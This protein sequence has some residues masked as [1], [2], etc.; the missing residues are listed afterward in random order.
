MVP[1]DWWVLLL[2]ISVVGLKGV[3]AKAFLLDDLDWQSD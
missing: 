3:H 2:I 1:G